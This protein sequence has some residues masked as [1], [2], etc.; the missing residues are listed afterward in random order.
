ME[1]LFKNRFIIAT[2][3][4][5]LSIFLLLCSCSSHSDHSEPTSALTDPSVQ[6]DSVSSTIQLE[7]SESSEPVLIKVATYNIFHAGKSR[8]DDIA[9]NLKQVEADI[10]GLQE[11]DEMTSRSRGASQ[12]KLIAEKAGYNYYKFIK[13]IDFQGGGYGTAIL[14]KYPII[15]FKNYQLESGNEETRTVGHALIDVDGR[16]INYFN[17][18]LSFEALSLRTAQFDFIAKKASNCN[19][20][21]ITGDF[22]TYDYS[23]FSPFANAKLVCN[24]E[25]TFCTFPGIEKAIDN[26]VYFGHFTE[27]I[28]GTLENDR[29]DHYLLWTILRLE[30]QN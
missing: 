4:L 17:T 1:L 2:L 15:S 29:S 28:S 19:E 16:K 27:I 9:D 21:I 18:H 24:N 7:T 10:V 14:S 20:Y 12:V 30:N 5:L 23:E 8:L 3:C 25:R 22:N 13:S 6:T 26:I 11:V